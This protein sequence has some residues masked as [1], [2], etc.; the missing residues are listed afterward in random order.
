MEV[1]HEHEDGPMADL[2]TLAKNELETLRSELQQTFD[3]KKAQG[4]A[5]DMTRGKPC[6]EQ[7]DLSNDLLAN[8]D[9]NEFSSPGGVDCRNYGGLDG[10]PE[11]K[12]IFADLLGVAPEQVVVG[13]N[14]SLAM[15]Q[16][17]VSCAMSHGVPGS[18]KPWGKE[19]KV[20]FLCPVP[21]YDRH[22]TI[23]SHAGIDMIAVPT[24]ENGPDMDK[25]ESLVKDDATIKGIWIVPKYANPTGN[26]CSDETVD[27]L[28][29]MKTAAPD[30]RILWDNA[31]AVHH[32]TDS[33]DQLKNLYDACA[34]AG[35]SDRALMFCSFSK[36]TFAGAGVSAVAASDANVEWV[37]SHLFVQTIGPDKVNQLRHIKFFKNFAGVEAHMKKHAGILK[38]KFDAVLA[39]LDEELSGKGVA[40]WTTPRGGY[41]IS[42]DVMHG[43]AKAVVARAADA[44]V[45][46]T[47][48]G[49]TFPRGEDPSDCNIRLAPT[50]PSTDD[51]LAAT[52]VVALCIQLVAV[53]KLLAG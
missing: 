6:S 35:H 42:L 5:L 50:F 18:A 11:M 16:N 1:T 9:K 33:P 27:R 46:L 48:A 41:F 3:E 22:F 37:K 4:L 40:T 8:L 21:G 44:G 23:C 39:I 20:T 7:L 28:A 31:Y 51:V 12:Q 19:E 32:L 38:P 10:L 2:T 34:A 13:G 17:A 25:V 24:D 29:G 43:C 45:K 49:A 15:M 36:V 53:E 26:T 47:K 52:R 14:S 30:F